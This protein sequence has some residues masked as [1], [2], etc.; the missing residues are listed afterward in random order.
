MKFM[1]RKRLTTLFLTAVAV[2]F[3]QKWGIP[4]EIQ[5]WLLGAVG[6]Y[7]LGQ[8]YSDGEAIKKG[9]KES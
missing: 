4:P 9:T 5:Q 2:P 8:S 6:A 3:M 7:M 1:L